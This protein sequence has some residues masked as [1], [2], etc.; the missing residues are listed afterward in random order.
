MKDFECPYCSH[1]MIKEDISEVHEDDVT[2]EWDITCRKC[3]KE[4]K[5]IAEPAITYEAHVK[6]E[7]EQGL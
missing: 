7:K 2:G 6:K 5:L 1:G 4:I 3:N